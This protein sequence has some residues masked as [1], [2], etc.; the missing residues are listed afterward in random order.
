MTR[1]LSSQNNDPSDP[2]DSDEGH[3]SIAHH[4]I[5]VVGQLITFVLFLGFVAYLV[6]VFS[7]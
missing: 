4:L 5:D 3:S 2:E 1:K 7:G 6:T